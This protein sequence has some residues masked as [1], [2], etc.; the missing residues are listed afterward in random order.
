LAAAALP[1]SGIDNEHR[2]PRSSLHYRPTNLRL[3]SF[4]ALVISLSTITGASWAFFDVAGQ[5]RLGAEHYRETDVYAD[6]GGAF[7]L[8]PSYRFYQSDYSNGGYNSWALRMGYDKPKDGLG[9]T[10]GSTPKQ[11]GYENE[12]AG[13]DAALSLGG[14]AASGV[15][16]GGDKGGPQEKEARRMGEDLGAGVTVTRHLEDFELSG[17]QTDAL[18]PGLQ[19]RPSPLTLV[20]TDLHG[21]AAVSWGWFW[22]GARVT[23]TL[24][25][26]NL[27]ELAAA[28]APLLEIEGAGA[29]ANGFPDLSVNGKMK[30]SFPD[31][32]EPYIS[33]THTS[34]VVEYPDS[35]AYTAGAFVYVGRLRVNG[36]YELYDPR[37]GIG[38]LG[39]YSLGVGWSF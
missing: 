16:S 32:I 20:Q 24:Y 19:S 39:F 33:Y 4:A 12:F 15:G 6:F 2:R 36:F 1:A 3:G 27:S 34:F 17:A 25:D 29:V 11:H 30:A 18:L 9:L 8:T 5:E 22:L 35:D 38:T 37:L 7:H 10:L 31:G 14:A 13:L 26:K 28:P 23:K 21:L